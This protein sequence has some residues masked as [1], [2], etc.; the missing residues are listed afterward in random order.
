MDALIKPPFSNKFEL[1][2]ALTLSFWHLSPTSMPYDS[3]MLTSSFLKQ[4]SNNSSDA[5]AKKSSTVSILKLS[6]KHP[7]A[8]SAHH[9]GAQHTCSSNKQGDPTSSVPN[10]NE[11]TK[12]T[13]RL[14][15]DTGGRYLCTVNQLRGKATSTWR[16]PLLPAD[17]PLSNSPTTVSARLNQNKSSSKRSEDKAQKE[18]RLCTTQG[19]TCI[20]TCIA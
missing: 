19:P 3:A 7:K 12:L 20:P 13:P 2:I 6:V 16:P 1:K 9:A 5:E 17:V 18:Q 15:A 10:Q 11:I 8:A 4:A 14:H